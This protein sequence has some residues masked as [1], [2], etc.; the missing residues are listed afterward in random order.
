MALLLAFHMIVPA[1]PTHWS[2]IQNT[3]YNGVARA[4]GFRD[5]AVTEI[6]G[7]GRRQWPHP[8]TGGYKDYNTFR[9]GP[10][11]L[12]AGLVL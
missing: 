5:C 1:F 4:M 12:H 3:W 10:S 11:D 7:S 9:G 2:S 6:I 8:H